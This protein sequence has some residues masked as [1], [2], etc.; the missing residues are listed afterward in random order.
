MSGKACSLVK[1][2]ANGTNGYISSNK[3]CLISQR[4]ISGLSM[5]VAIICYLST[6]VNLQWAR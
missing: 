1:E 6:S 3:H 4:H 5:A 2:L